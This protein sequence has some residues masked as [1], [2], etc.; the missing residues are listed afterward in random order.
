MRTFVD[1]RLQV[2]ATRVHGEE[3]PCF[4][5]K[6]VGPDY[7]LGRG[8]CDRVRL[9]EELGE[10]QVHSEFSVRKAH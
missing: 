6:K 4:A 7:S 5:K 9:P 3:T 2:I 1:G 10:G 8:E